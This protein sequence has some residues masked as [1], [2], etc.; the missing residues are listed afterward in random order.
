M[1]H[2]NVSYHLVEFVQRAF[3]SRKTRGFLFIAAN[4][5][6]TKNSKQIV[7]DVYVNK[8]GSSLGVRY[9]GFLIS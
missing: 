9:R 1:L 7:V 3:C 5:T 8:G 2:T 4:F 6:V